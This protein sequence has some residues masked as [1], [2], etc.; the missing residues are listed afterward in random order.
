MLGNP[1]GNR[2]AALPR[3]FLRKSGWRFVRI[4]SGDDI[5][6]EYLVLCAQRR[7][8]FCSV[9]LQNG[10]IVRHDVPARYVLLFH[11]ALAMASERG[12]LP[13]L[14]QLSGQLTRFRF[15]I[16]RQEELEWTKGSLRQEIDVRCD[17]FDTDLVA[18][19]KP[20]MRYFGHIHPLAVQPTV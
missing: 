4:Q 9:N 7:T 17:I 16:R 14:S 15:A 2:H 10:L 8:S 3:D 11:P 12:Y 5:R 1:D 6:I 13:M 19:A 18:S 20:S